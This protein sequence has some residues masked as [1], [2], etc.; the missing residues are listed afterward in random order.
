MRR[1]RVLISMALFVAV[2]LLIASCGATKKYFP[3]MYKTPEEVTYFEEVRIAERVRGKVLYAWGVGQGHTEEEAM[4]MAEE[5]ARIK[6]QAISDIAKADNS[7]RVVKWV[8]SRSPYYKVEVLMS[9]DTSAVE[10]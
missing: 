1:V 6:L 2:V 3:K 10:Q 5:I 7:S 4:N 8:P 9:I